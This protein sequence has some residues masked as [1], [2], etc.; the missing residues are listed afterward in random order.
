[1]R[2]KFYKLREEGH[3]YIF[4]TFQAWIWEELTFAEGAYTPNSKKAR[5]TENVLK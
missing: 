2:E 4:V 3:F 1:M 5:E